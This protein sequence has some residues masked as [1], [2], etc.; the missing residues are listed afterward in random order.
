MHV[1]QS[2]QILSTMVTD[3]DTQNFA[4][5]RAVHDESSDDESSD[6][7]SGQAQVD[8]NLRSIGQGCKECAQSGL[9]ASQKVHLRTGSGLRH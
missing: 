9:C 4:S 2:R 6:D 8:C 5:L 1:T 7:E 3:P